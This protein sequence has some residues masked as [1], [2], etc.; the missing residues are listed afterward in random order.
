MKLCVNILTESS[1]KN[2]EG[3]SNTNV[4]NGSLVRMVLFVLIIWGG[5]VEVETKLLV[6]PKFYYTG[7]SL[8]HSRLS[9]VLR[10]S[11]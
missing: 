8:V 3:D 10:L 7:S 5:E 6:P 1:E 2:A 9:C 11:L 4:L